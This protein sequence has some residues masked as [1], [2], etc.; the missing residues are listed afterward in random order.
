[1]DQSAP[2]APLEKAAPDSIDPTVTLHVCVK[3]RAGDD[4]ETEPRAG[5]RLHQALIEARRDHD[6]PPSI[7]I[8]PAEC[9][10]NC[11]RGCS[12][13]LTGPGRWSYVYGD[14]GETSAADLLAGARQYAATG[15]GLVP[16]RERPAIFRKG[17]VARI[18]P[19]ERPL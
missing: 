3:C 2:G 7:R 18:P 4:S 19:L 9:L 5:A 12:V 10:S 15:D 1:M 14:L 16:W 11:N 8:A 13:A 17:V 6:D